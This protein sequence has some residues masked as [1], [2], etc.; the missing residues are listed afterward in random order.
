MHQAL[1]QSVKALGD[2]GSVAMIA[3]GVD[4]VRIDAA[5][6]DSIVPPGAPSETETVSHVDG[7]LHGIDVEP[8]EIRIRDASGQD[9][10]CR[11]TPDI[12]AEEAA[13]LGSQV[14]AEVDAPVPPRS[15]VLEVTRL[16]PLDA[17]GGPRVRRGQSAAEVIAA[18]LATA[19]ITAPQPLEALRGDVDPDDPEEAA[20]VEALRSFG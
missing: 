14:R 4:P 2:G 10:P 8:D 19:D 7:W 20:F 5:V 11:F 18:A 1:V 12:E 9:W 13:L 17:G 6:L 3:P 16:Q 15:A